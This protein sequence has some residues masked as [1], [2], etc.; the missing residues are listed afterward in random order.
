A[1]FDLP[2]V[3][4]H[5][6]EVFRLTGFDQARFQGR[7]QGWTAQRGGVSDDYARWSIVQSLGQGDANFGVFQQGD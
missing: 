2:G 1:A 7:L 4:R 6:D 5:R 3:A